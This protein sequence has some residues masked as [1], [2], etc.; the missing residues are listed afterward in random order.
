MRFLAIVCI[1]FGPC[2]RSCAKFGADIQKIHHK[3]NLMDCVD[4]GKC[5]PRG[6]GS[7]K[8]GIVIVKMHPR[9][10]HFKLRFARRFSYQYP[11]L[12]TLAVLW[13]NY[14]ADTTFAWATQCKG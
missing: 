12:L 9:T 2:K 3:K 1:F 11:V 6:V 10:S 4:F 13:P 5:F 8:I 14:N 7:R